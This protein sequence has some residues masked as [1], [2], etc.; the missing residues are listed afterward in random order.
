[1]LKIGTFFDSE[2]R[3][4]YD[5]YTMNALKLKEAID[6]SYNLTPFKINLLNGETGLLH[7]IETEL[8]YATK[9]STN[10]EVDF[11]KGIIINE[12]EYVSKMSNAYGAQRIIEALSSSR[13]FK[14]TTEDYHQLGFELLP[15][16]IAIKG[17]DLNNLNKA[18]LI[19]G[20]RRMFWTKNIPDRDV[21]VKVYDHLTH[22]EWINAMLMY[23]SWKLKKAGSW[24]ANPGAG[25]FVDRGFK[26]GL[27]KKF[28][29][30]LTTHGTL[31]IEMVNNYIYPST[32]EVLKDNP[33]F[34]DDIKL[35]V[36]I[37]SNRQNKVTGKNADAKMYYFAEFVRTFV[38]ILRDI[39]VLEFNSNRRDQA[40]VVSYEATKA[41]LETK[42]MA[43]HIEK[44]ESM[45]TI[46]AIN[47]YIIK[48]VIP[49]CI[50]FFRA[51]YGLETSV[52]E[53]IQ[54][55][56]DFFNSMRG[57]F[58]TK[59]EMDNMKKAIDEKIEEKRLKTMRLD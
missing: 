35:I 54:R 44:I 32:Y 50:E 43:K 23:N 9:G 20:F 40:V 39:R 56:Y 57:F 42:V 25:D 5:L 29:V 27:Y 51:Q 6:K 2:V 4:Y 1:M 36:D 10:L 15:I 49:L 47:N 11:N 38:A 12:K 48:H 26:L 24:R 22:Q 55:P 7:D 58:L 21:F 16:A 31:T 18:E 30:D 14:N 45:S 52:T 53:Y 28:G 41:F 19:D 34:L 59:D 13:G 8:R 46:G 37:M 33:L 17:R 3:V